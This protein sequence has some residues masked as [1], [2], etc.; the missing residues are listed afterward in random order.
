MLSKKVTK[1]IRNARTEITRMSNKALGELDASFAAIK[2]S[3]DLGRDG[4]SDMTPDDLTFGEP[5]VSW[6]ELKDYPNISPERKSYVD[7]YFTRFYKQK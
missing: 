7:A 2:E 4:P 1:M 6:K 5:P 3:L